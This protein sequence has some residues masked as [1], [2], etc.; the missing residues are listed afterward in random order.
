MS[1][2]P[3]REAR[4]IHPGG[5][6]PGKERRRRFCAGVGTVWTVD[7]LVASAGVLKGAYRTITEFEEADWDATLDT[8]LKGT[9]L[10][11]K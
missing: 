7:I 1:G 5:R 4:H 10:T 9:F 3:L 6:S 11:A 8:N 2:S